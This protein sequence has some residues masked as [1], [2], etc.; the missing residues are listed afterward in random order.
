MQEVIVIFDSGKVSKF[1]GI[2]LNVS[3]KIEKLEKFGLDKEKYLVIENEI[4]SKVFI[5]KKESISGLEIV[6]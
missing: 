2:I 3:D 6:Y 1:Q 4:E 5:I